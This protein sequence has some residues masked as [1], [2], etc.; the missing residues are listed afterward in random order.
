MTQKS[1]ANNRLATILL[2][3]DEPH[4]TEALKR[5]FRREHY[6][7]L[8]AASALEA[9]TILEQRH[10]DVVVSDEQM[11]GL[12]G[13]QLLSWVRERFPHTIRMILS[14]QASLQAAVRA[15][16]EGEVYRFFL[17]PCN[18]TDLMVT[19]RQALATKK[20]EEQSRRLLREYQRQAALLAQVN[21]NAPELLRLDIDERGALVV[22]EA[23]G[24]GELS[25]LL[26]EIELAMKR[27]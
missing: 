17:K 24:E 1:D 27:A 8:T 26:A 18:P 6:E 10:V 14:G 20:L 9:Q 13:S 16:N 12:S 22:D 4:V 11:P 23:D 3:D 21:L 15:I 25:D 2:V 7:F 19:I 5:A